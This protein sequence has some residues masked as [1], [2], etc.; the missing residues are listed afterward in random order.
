MRTCLSRLAKIARVWPPAPF[1]AGR[2]A[3]WLS[4]VVKA[5]KTVEVRPVKV[6]FTQANVS[7]IDSG[8]SPG[9]LVVTDGQDKLQGGS[10][11]EPHAQTPGSPARAT[12]PAGT[13]GQ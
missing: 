13:V 7:A 8:L 12:Q 2:R 1:R 6:A 3:G 9:D 5:D 4:Y 11:V 10:R